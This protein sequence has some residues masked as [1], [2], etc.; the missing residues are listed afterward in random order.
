MITLEK[1]ATLDLSAA[2]ALVSNGPNVL[3]VADDDLMLDSYATATGRRVDRIR[4]LDR[5]LPTAADA[6]K[7]AKPDFEAL[8]WLPD[9]RLLVLGSGSTERRQTGVVLA[10]PSSV[11]GPPRAPREV[12][13]TPL[14][15]ALRARLPHLNIEGAA[16][17]SAD[18][19]VLLSRGGA[20]RD[21]AAVELDLHALLGALDAGAPL[22]RAL[23]RDVQVVELGSLEGVALGFTD[24]APL[25]RV[26]AAVEAASPTE[27]WRIA[28]AAAAEDTD[29]AYDDG[30]CAG[31][32]VGV[33]RPSGRVALVERVSGQHKIEGLDVH[34][35]RLLMVADPDD[36]TQR[37]P[38]FRAPPMPAWLL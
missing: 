34:S 30:A 7:A 5:T 8:T 20:G 18:T 32:V 12:D 13:L 23:V 15:G 22:G 1:I 21:N 6:R 35:D 28:F 24:A 2:S 26:G 19:L 4:L 9:G 29:N 16:V 17:A 27:R 38:L 31:S 14:Y 37:A 36:P 33:L 10:P 3:V 11:D 25:P